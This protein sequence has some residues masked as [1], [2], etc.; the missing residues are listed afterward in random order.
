MS[1]DSIFLHG[2]E[3]SSDKLDQE[4]T[5]VMKIPLR[6]PKDTSTWYISEKAKFHLYL[7]QFELEDFIKEKPPTSPTPPTK[8]KK[9]KNI[10]TNL[11]LLDRYDN[12][13]AQYKKDIQ[14]Y[15]KKLKKLYFICY[16][17]VDKTHLAHLQIRFPQEHFLMDPR[18]FYFEIIKTYETHQLEAERTK[19]LQS[20]HDYIPKEYDN[21]KI[22]VENTITDIESFHFALRNLP[23][24]LACKFTTFDK[25]QHLTAALLRDKTR[26][27]DDILQ[28]IPATINYITLKSE[29]IA[30]IDNL[31]NLGLLK[32]SSASESKSEHLRNEQAN[33]TITDLK[34]KQHELRSQLRQ[35]NHDLDIRFQNSSNSSYSNIGSNQYQP[36][37]RFRPS[38]DDNRNFRFNSH[39]SGFGDPKKNFDGRNY[40]S[41]NKTFAS[42]INNTVRDHNKFRN[43]K[44]NND[45]NHGQHPYPKRTKFDNRKFPNKGSYSDSHQPNSRSNSNRNFNSSSSDPRN[46]AFYTEEGSQENDELDGDENDYDRDDDDR[47]DAIYE[48]DD[49]S[50]YSYHSKNDDRDCVYYGD[51]NGDN[52]FSP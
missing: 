44:S 17:Y 43:A 6:A 11:R 51:E 25:R 41:N 21:L 31:A 20:I 22:V 7:A 46:R 19:L 35:V 40:H 49:Q 32:P 34:S 36:Q 3:T 30:K 5:L 16:M 50:E 29:I 52:P 28:D 14:Q 48:P 10:K 24:R 38:Y 39:Y 1:L 9:T 13:M 47:H 2:S 37:K 33:S 4:L 42:N 15:N 45:Y 26:R 27:F 18:P 23:N 12:K 8:Q